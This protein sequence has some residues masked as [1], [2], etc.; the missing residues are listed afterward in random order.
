MKITRSQLKQLI[1]EEL[2]VPDRLR[3]INGAMLELQSAGHFGIEPFNE[4]GGKMRSIVILEAA[5]KTVIEALKDGLDQD[6]GSSDPHLSQ[7]ME[8]FSEI[9]A[10]RIS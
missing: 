4:E 3:K 9:D 1:T 6:V 8:I 10:S 7:V 2:N 5:F